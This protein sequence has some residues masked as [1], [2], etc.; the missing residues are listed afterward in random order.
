MADSKTGSESENLSRIKDILFGEDLQSIEQKL[1]FFKKENSEINSELKTEI[2]NRFSSL[3]KSINDKLHLANNFNQE[4]LESQ[5]K[6]NGET[7]KEISDL[8]GKIQVEKEKMEANLSQ[9]NEKILL[10]ITELEKS[11]SEVI[12]GLKNEQNVKLEELRINKLSKENV[13]K[14]LIEMAEKLSK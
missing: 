11:L 12:K 5:N 6:T 8:N 14:L 7:K 9:Q 10:K 13:S 3:E 2:E 1:A 4:C